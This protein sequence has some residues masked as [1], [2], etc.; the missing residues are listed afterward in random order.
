MR[1]VRAANAH[2]RRCYAWSVALDRLGS[3]VRCVMP[4]ESVLSWLVW[5]RRLRLD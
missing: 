1:A 2:P 4:G 3:E 5:G